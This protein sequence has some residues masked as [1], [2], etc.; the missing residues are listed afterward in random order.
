MVQRVDQ[1]CQGNGRGGGTMIQAQSSQ[2][3]RECFAGVSGKIAAL[4]IL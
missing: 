1:R 4:P 2:R 3:A